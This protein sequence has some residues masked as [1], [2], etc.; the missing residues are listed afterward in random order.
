MSRYASKQLEFIADE[1]AS[2][3]IGNRGPSHSATD[4]WCQCHGSPFV[5]WDVDTTCAT[6]TAALDAPNDIGARAIQI[7]EERFSIGNIDNRI[8]QLF[9]NAASRGDI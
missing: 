9:T 1:V 3:P 7:I 6:L 2:V 5:G 8:E 4:P